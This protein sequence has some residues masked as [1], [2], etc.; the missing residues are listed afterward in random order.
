MKLREGRRWVTNG[1]SGVGNWAGR[2]LG[3][4]L[5][6]SLGTRSLKA[7]S[8]EASISRN[9][10][11][12]GQRRG[13]GWRRVSGASLPSLCYLGSVLLVLPGWLPTES[14]LCV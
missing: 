7:Q 3:G 11:L 6:S 13:G 5:A 12:R 2:A 1:E 4:H 10:L 14:S 9:G 8:R